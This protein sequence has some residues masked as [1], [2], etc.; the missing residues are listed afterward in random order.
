M[1]MVHVLI[2]DYPW[3]F[4][5]S[6]TDSNVVKWLYVPDFHTAPSSMFLICMCHCVALEMSLIVSVLAGVCSADVRFLLSSPLSQMTSCCCCVP[7]SRGRSLMMRTRRQSASWLETTW[8]SA[9]TWTQ[10]LSASTTPSPTSSTA[11]TAAYT[12]IM[13]RSHCSRKW[14]ECLMDPILVFQRLN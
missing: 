2:S 3:R 1:I 12:D 7:L 14:P 11:G 9:E 13:L 6:T 4:P 8:R 5:N 10:P